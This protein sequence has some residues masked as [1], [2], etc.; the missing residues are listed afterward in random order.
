MAGAAAPMA[1]PVTPP[2]TRP[3]DPA[4]PMPGQALPSRND[5]HRQAAAPQDTAKAAPA[6]ADQGTKQDTAKEG[7]QKP[8]DKPGEREPAAQLVEKARRE[9]H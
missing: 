4:P 2:D 7:G 3:A 8:P 9:G 6:P 1:I 5:D